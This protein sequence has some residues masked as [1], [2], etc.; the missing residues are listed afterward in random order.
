MELRED[1]EIAVEKNWEEWGEDMG[2][3]FRDFE[4]IF[5]AGWYAYASSLEGGV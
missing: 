4:N 1:I 5:L 3:S 2:L